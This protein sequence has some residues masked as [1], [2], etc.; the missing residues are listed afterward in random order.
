MPRVF[1][2]ALSLAIS[3]ILEGDAPYC[4]D[5]SASFLLR[6]K[7]GSSGLAKPWRA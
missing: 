6:C 5:T 2:T 1:L 3:L 4:F 7:P